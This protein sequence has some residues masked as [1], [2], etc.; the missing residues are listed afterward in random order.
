MIEY[1]DMG[2]IARVDE[3]DHDPLP[4]VAQ[5]A[6]R[7]ELAGRRNQVKDALAELDVPALRRLMQACI[8]LTSAAAQCVVAQSIDAKRQSRP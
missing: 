7:H 2:D 3:H 1:D 6:L 4:A 5:N 8:V